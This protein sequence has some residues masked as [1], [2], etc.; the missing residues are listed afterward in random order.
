MFAGQLA[1]TGKSLLVLC[2]AEDREHGVG[3]DEVSFKYWMQQEGVSTGSLYRWM[4]KPDSAPLS[5]DSATTLGRNRLG[6]ILM[7][8]RDGTLPDADTPA[9]QA[10]EEAPASPD[11]PLFTVGNLA[12]SDNVVALRGPFLPLS[13][14]SLFLP[15]SLP[16]P[17]SHSHN[18]GPGTP[19]P[20]PSRA[21]TTAPWSTTSTTSSSTPTESRRRKWR[22]Y[23]QRSK[24]CNAF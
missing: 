4:L 23:P 7:E 10:V 18:H 2:D 8:L 16:L 22:R 21:S 15:S 14:R 12:V 24:L 13:N 11:R 17:R 19:S 5:V 9:D 6:L 20:S 3:M 1:K